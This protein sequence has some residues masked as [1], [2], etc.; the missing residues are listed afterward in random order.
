MCIRDSAV[1]DPV[2]RCVV[3]GDHHPVARGVHVGLEIA[4]AQ[5]DG[6]DE[7]L[8]GVLT[9]DVVW[10]QRPAAMRQSDGRRVE[11]GK[12]T[13]RTMHAGHSPAVS[14]SRMTWPNSV[15]VRPS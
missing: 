7:R 4:K 15:A 1:G 2:Q 8:Q 6:G 10:V 3:E 11:V 5:A 14:R 9:P 12:V 13:R